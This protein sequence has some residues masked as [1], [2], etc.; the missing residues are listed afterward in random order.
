MPC[1]YEKK[2][3]ASGAPST[4]TREARASIPGNAKFSY[5]KY[6]PIRRLLFSKF[7]SF[8]KFGEKFKSDMRIQGVAQLLMF[9]DT[10]PAIVCSAEPLLV[11]AYS[12]EMDAVVMLKFPSELVSM[13]DLR[14]GTRLVTSNYYAPK[15]EPFAKDIFVGEDHS[16]NWNDF[17]PA[18]QLFLAKND[19]K[20]KKR[21]ELFNEEIWAKVEKLAADYLNEHP[22]TARD[23]FF[24][25]R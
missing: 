7:G 15:N 16:N 2:E 18:V 21:T 3:S 17:Y 12:D 20:I 19:E 14:I 23:G 4:P 22:D 10:Q 5:K 11:A 25:F 9:G 6:Y 13:Y 24:Y 8:S 1:V